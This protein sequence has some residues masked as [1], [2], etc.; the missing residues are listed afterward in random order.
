M[1]RINLVVAV[2]LLACIMATQYGL[3][4]EITPAQAE[5]SSVRGDYQKTFPVENISEISLKIPN[6]VV[7]VSGSAEA[8]QI[9]LKGEYSVQGK[10]PETCEKL[11]EKI[12]I[13]DKIDGQTLNINAEIKDRK[14][15]DINCYLEVII[16]WDMNVVVNVKS[17]LA[18]IR[19]TDGKVQVNVRNGDVFCDNLSGSLE[20]F[21]LNGGM[22]ISELSGHANGISGN[23][24]TTIQCD[25]TLP[26]SL[27]L[28][29]VNGGVRVKLHKIPDATL[30]ALSATAYVHLVGEDNL[31]NRLVRS[32]E[33]TLGRGT[34]KYSIQ[35]LNGSVTLDLP[36]V[37]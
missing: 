27:D 9:I 34:N 30:S 26:A 12:K 37:Q 17:G 35:S 20:F 4:L 18:E 3:P 28:V 5:E 33:A 10:K 16:P 36:K 24:G 31:A 15:Y 14:H 7:L 32:Y 2:L 22:F 13:E 19:N 25:D 1:K 6:G 11:L 29:S 23:G 8:D 21:V